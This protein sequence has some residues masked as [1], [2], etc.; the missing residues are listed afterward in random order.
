MRIQTITLQPIHKIS[1]LQ[2]TS[3]GTAEIAELP[4]LQGFVEALPP[5]IDSIVCV[6]DLQGIG[7]T[8]Q[9][10]QEPKLLGELLA[11]ELP[12]LLESLRVSPLHTGIVLAGDFY[13]SPQANQRGVSGD[14]RQVWNAFRQRFGWV[15]GVLGNHD[16]LGATPAEL[17]RFV[18]QPNLFYLDG[19][20]CSVA[21]L[22]IAGISGIIGNPTKPLRRS[23]D[24]YLSMLARLRQTKPD[25]IILHPSPSVPKSHYLGADELGAA[26]ERQ[27]YPL[28]VCGHISWP[29]PLAEL[30][31]GT[32][33]LNIDSRAI[34]L[35]AGS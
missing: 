20:T 2:A 5:T 35:R 14:V 12:D 15:A 22:S 32:Q 16:Q 17:N 10:S 13:S 4:I 3:D 33:I 6:S 31:N 34:I 1:Y 18:Q 23:A 24:E 11:E 29:Q 26:Y 19:T 30:Q 28:T 7:I 21:G 27:E 8:H 25:L 9:L